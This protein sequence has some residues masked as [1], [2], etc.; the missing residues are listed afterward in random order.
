MLHG[1]EAFRVASNIKGHQGKA[2][3]ELERK[4]SSVRMF[5]YQE[6][7]MPKVKSPRFKV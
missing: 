7:K 6:Y 5:K 2:K 4:V 1:L 3:D